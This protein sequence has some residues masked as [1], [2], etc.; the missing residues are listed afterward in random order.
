MFGRAGFL[1][2][3]PRLLPQRAHNG[4]LCCGGGPGCPEVAGGVQIG[5]QGLTQR[6]VRREGTWRSLFPVF[7][8]V[9]GGIGLRCF[10]WGEW[11][12]SGCRCAFD[13]ID[14][15]AGRFDGDKSFVCER[16]DV[17]LL[18]YDHTAANFQYRK[19]FFVHQFVAAGSGTA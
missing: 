1:D 2:C 6:F 16:E 17:L 4:F 5:S 8:V 11:Y 13:R 12:S 9:A 3:C 14:D 15:D 7:G 19:I 10:G 18:W